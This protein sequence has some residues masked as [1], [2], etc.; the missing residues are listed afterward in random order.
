MESSIDIEKKCYNPSEPKK[1]GLTVIIM[2]INIDTTGINFIF[3]HS[4]CS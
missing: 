3:V 2:V 1:P 4:K